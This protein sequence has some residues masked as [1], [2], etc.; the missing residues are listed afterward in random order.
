M[1]GLGRRPGVSLAAWW[2][3]G[4]KALSESLRNHLGHPGKVPDEGLG[5]SLRDAR[6]SLAISGH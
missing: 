4:S 1:P 2:G 5:A 3:R 6:P